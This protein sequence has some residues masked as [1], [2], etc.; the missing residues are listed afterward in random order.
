MKHLQ[1][2]IFVLL[3][4]LV[5]FLP[6]SCAQQAAIKI[7][8]FEVLSLQVTPAEVVEGQEITVTAQVYN[9][10]NMPGNFDE[11]LLVNEIRVNAKVVTLQPG[12]TKTITYTIIVNKPGTYE[13]SLLDVNTKFNVKSMVQKDIE[14]KYD[15]GSSRTALWAGYNGGFLISFTPEYL[16]FQLSK[17]QICGGTYGVGWEG[18]SFELWVLD[19]DMQSVIFN[20]SYTI[21]KFPV[22]GAYPYQP[23]VWVDFDIN[24]VSLND[25]FFVYLYTSTDENKGVHVGVDDTPL[26]ENSALA[27]GRPPYV[28][29]IPLKNLY[30]STIWYSD[31]SKVNWMIRAVGTSLI[32]GQ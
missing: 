3:A 27:Q 26:N 18:K 29:I 21:D 19:S 16:P 12:A 25:K 13:V 14:L 2:I 28:T 31:I 22:R 6:T 4:M 9:T 24:P 15:T 8:S 7:A 17:I 32:P 30:F 1:K 11:P 23:P 5:V 20:Q 10:G